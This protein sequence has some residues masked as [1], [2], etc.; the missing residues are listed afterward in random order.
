[1]DK[2]DDISVCH[3]TRLTS[4]VFLYFQTRVV[5]ALPMDDQVDHVVDHINDDL[6]D[7]QTND[8]LASFNRDAGTIPCA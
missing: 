6:G 4:F 7:Q 8:F 5:S 3:P 2:I 1:M